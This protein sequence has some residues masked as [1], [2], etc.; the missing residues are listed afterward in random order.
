MATTAA[1][2]GG[3]GGGEGAMGKEGVGSGEWIREGVDKATHLPP[4]TTR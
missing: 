3:G 4:S 1:G 2:E